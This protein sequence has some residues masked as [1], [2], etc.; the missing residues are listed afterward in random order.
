MAGFNSVSLVI[1]LVFYPETKLVPLEQMD[2]VF[3]DTNRV[4]AAR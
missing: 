4:L 2:E 3:G 1:L